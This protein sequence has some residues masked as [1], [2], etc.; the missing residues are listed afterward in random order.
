MGAGVRQVTLTPSSTAHTNESL[1]ACVRWVGSDSGALTAC[2]PGSVF[3][4]G[5]QILFLFQESPWGGGQL[6][7]FPIQLM[8]EL[9]ASPRH[10]CGLPAA[11]AAC[12]SEE[13]WFLVFAKNTQ[14]ELTAFR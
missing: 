14:V 5:P 13:E 11:P 4:V 6:N 8:V 3:P 12:G 10:S 9:M 1:R 2:T 7:D